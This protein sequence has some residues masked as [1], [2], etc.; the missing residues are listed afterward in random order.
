MSDDLISKLNHTSVVLPHHGEII[1]LDTGALINA[2]SEAMIQALHSRSTGGL[3]AHLAVL[4][5]KGARNFMSGFY[6]GYGHKSIGD[7][8][9]TTIFIEGVSMLAAKAIQ[10]S[11]L[12]AGQEASTRYIDF[13]QQPFIDP[14]RT[15][16]GA[17][18][19][20]S[21]RAIYL[22]AQEPTR[23]SLRKKHPRVEG[24]VEKIYEKAISAR[25]FDIN[26][27]LLPAGVSTNL[28]WHTS[29]RHAAD[30]MLFLRHHPLTEVREIAEGL[31]EALK[32]HHPNS[33]G[34]KKYS[35]TEAYQDVIAVDYFFHDLNSPEKAIVDFSGIDR[36]EFEI[37]R[38]LLA[39]RPVKTEIP[40]Y[41]SQAGVVS[42][43]FQLDFG[44]FR[45]IQRHRSIAQR[46]PLLTSELGFNQWYVENLPEEVRNY[47]SNHLQKVNKGIEK[48]RVT[49]QEA[50]YFLPMGYNVSNRF[51]GDIPAS[52]YMVELRDTRFV[53][54]T[55]Q[56]V[57]HNIGD[58]LVDNLGIPIHRDSE[59]GR[60]DIMRGTHDIVT[61]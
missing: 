11:P 58:Q 37:F 57:A 16:T 6:V 53:H 24:E 18:L 4:A 25:A 28:A 7:C 13:S 26:R 8:G 30:R 5:K 2:E 21:Q 39:R 50:Q 31:E 36:K 42:A 9:T 35:E 55:L 22:A 3:R 56:R 40:K 20:E 10:D 23:T 32:I 43:E 61:K 14:T 54:P 12:Y 45:D 51:T 29:L 38:S 34:H 46:M 33:F 60:F 1:V 52:V 44:S 47:L 17:E 41:V 27:S 15:S 49:R 59:P 48:L 19:L